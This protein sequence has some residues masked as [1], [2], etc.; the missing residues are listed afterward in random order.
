M[1]D[2]VEAERAGLHR[3]LAARLQHQP[4]RRLRQAVEDG[5]ADGHE[6]ERDPVI[7]VGVDGDD[8]G[9]R[10]ADLAAGQV[11]EH[12]DEILQH[13]HC[14]QGGQ[15]E[16]GA[17]DPERRQGQHEARDD[18]R[19]R[20][21]DDADVDR[22]AVLVVDD[23]RGVGADADQEGRTKIHFAREPEQQVPGHCEDAEIVGDCEQA[24]N[25][26]G[27]IERQGRRDDDHQKGNKKQPRFDKITHAHR[28][29]S[30]P[31]GRIYMTT[32]RSSKAGIVR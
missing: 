29:P 20:T 30:R 17:A 31:C 13:Q 5:G 10:Q 16:I 14:D 8:V 22:P 4:E 15:A 6:A 12:D 18:R 9:D 11:G 2:D 21:K 25:I 28:L 27:D 23:A 1:L 24:E 26:A 7:G 32:T 3:V 19:E